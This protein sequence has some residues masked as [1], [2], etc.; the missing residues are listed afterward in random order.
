M[1][2]LPVLVARRGDC[3]MQVMKAS[4]YGADRDTIR[5]LEGDGDNALFLYR[6]RIYAEQPVLF[7]VADQILMR[8]LRRLGLVPHEPPVLAV[9]ANRSCAA[10][11][12]PWSQL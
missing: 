10:E 6:G 8:L 12:L 2:G 4:Y 1:D 11:T 7:I 5:A 9:V 3:G